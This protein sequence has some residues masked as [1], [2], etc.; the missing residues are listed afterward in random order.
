MPQKRLRY[1]SDLS[2]RITLSQLP[3][4]ILDK[5]MSEILDR[6]TLLSLALVSTVFRGVFNMRKW[7]FLRSAYTKEASRG[8]YSMLFEVTWEGLIYEG[9]LGEAFDFIKSLRYKTNYDIL[10]QL[11][12]SMYDGVVLRTWEA[13]AGAFTAVRFLVTNYPSTDNTE[14]RKRL[15]RQAVSRRQEII[16]QSTLKVQWKNP[17]F[18]LQKLRFEVAMHYKNKKGDDDQAE[19]V[20]ATITFTIQERLWYEASLQVLRLITLD[21][22][23]DVES[24]VQKLETICCGTIS[25]DKY[26]YATQALN[27]FLKNDI[28]RESKD[29]S[30]DVIPCVKVAIGNIWGVWAMAKGTRWATRHRIFNQMYHH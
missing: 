26:H 17:Y 7:G 27:I 6:R 8:E 14:I 4:E 5:I 18:V 22:N 13:W 11:L 20:L 12:Q 16:H 29:K 28:F 1:S 15:I 23:I 24:L 19:V 25:D 21:I 3:V 2:G 30:R 10:L 9:R